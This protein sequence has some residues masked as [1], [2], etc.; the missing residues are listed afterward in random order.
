[1]H[2]YTCAGVDLLWWC[3]WGGWCFLL[4]ESKWLLGLIKSTGTAVWLRLGGPLHIRADR[5]Q[6][7]IFIWNPFH[8]NLS[9]PNAGQGYFMFPHS[10]KSYMIQFFFWGGWVCKKPTVK[11]NLMMY[12]LHCKRCISRVLPWYIWALYSDN[13][14]PQSPSGE[15]QYLPLCY[16]DNRTW[17]KNSLS[18]LSQTQNM[19]S[20]LPPIHD[21]AECALLIH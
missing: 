6:Q 5:T 15:K 4:M 2:A 16:Q 7:S 3:W 11:E 20:I 14:S 10:A 13:G 1:M 8:L 18:L 9:T 21:K 19:S 12:H 17:H